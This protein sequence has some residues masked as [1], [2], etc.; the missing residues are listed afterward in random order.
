MVMINWLKGFSASKHKSDSPKTDCKLDISPS[1]FQ[2]WTN[3]YTPNYRSEVKMQ[4]GSAG[5]KHVVNSGMLHGLLVCSQWVMHWTSQQHIRKWW[6][7]ERASGRASGLSPIIT[8]ITMGRTVQW[9]QLWAED[10]CVASA[11]RQR[12]RERAACFTSLAGQRS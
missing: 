4:A 9:K 10:P 12:W 1:I 11:W 2:S 3:V 6:V 8:H 7:S 5:V